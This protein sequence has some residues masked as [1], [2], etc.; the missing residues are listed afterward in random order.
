[1][2]AI[3]QANEMVNRPNSDGSISQVPRYALNHANSA[4]EYVSRQIPTGAVGGGGTQTSPPAQGGAPASTVA[5]A[6]PLAPPARPPASAAPRPLPAPTVR[7]AAKAPDPVD[8][9]LADSKYDLPGNTVAGRTPSI[10]EESQA[11]GIG[12][13]RNA[14][15]Q[16]A[17]QTV[18]S[19]ATALQ[20]AQAAKQILDS[21]GAPVTGIL[22]KP[23]A[24]ISSVFGGVDASNYQ[25][26][27]KY[28]GNLAVQ[29]GKG[30]FPHATEKENMVQFEQLSPSAG[31]TEDALKSLL[32]TNIKTSQ[33]TLDTANR[34]TR[35]LDPAKNK[36]PQSFFRWN[37]EHFPR[38]DA[39]NAGGAKQISSKAEYDALPKNAAYIYNGRQGVKQ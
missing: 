26:V 1:M 38:A 39:I 5:P 9:A 14:L 21:K 12:E 36:D 27:A 11:K 30:N 3:A 7:P 19:S 25:E 35:Y 33:Y 24:I 17:E 31:M 6:R 8:V 28:L 18:Q 13:A 23:A 34:V 10:Q 37:Q 4:A 2:E 16:D 15:K 32:N 22:G 29:S 20:Y